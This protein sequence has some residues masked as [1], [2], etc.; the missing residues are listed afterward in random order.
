MN[1]ETLNAPG[2][3]DLLAQRAAEYKSQSRKHAIA[4]GGLVLAEAVSA[5]VSVATK[6]FG[7]LGGTIAF[8]TPIVASNIYY[9]DD[10]AK[11]ASSFSNAHDRLVAST[12]NFDTSM[13]LI[14]GVERALEEVA[15][16]KNGKV[17]TRD[18][19][20]DIADLQRAR[21]PYVN[22]YVQSGDLKV[23]EAQTDAVQD[24]WLQ[25]KA[26]NREF[27]PP[28]LVM[29]T[30]QS[31]EG[32]YVKQIWLKTQ[33]AECEWA[34]AK[35]TGDTEAA[36]QADWTFYAINMNIDRG[37]NGKLVEKAATILN[38]KQ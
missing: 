35:L 36:R 10:R 22:K 8:L 4:A 17:L 2:L 18:R 24:A 38:V 13:T 31:D 9:A 25:A 28:A 32:D 23:L 16:L 29:R 37:L 19:L 34:Y 7:T 33:V 3:K 1:Y 26:E 15:D 14:N 6:N 11:L 30:G 27:E 5:C 21:M 12:R 20:L